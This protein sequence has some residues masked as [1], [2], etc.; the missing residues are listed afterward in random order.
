MVDALET[1]YSIFSGLTSL[2]QGLIQRDLSTPEADTEGRFYTRGWYTGPCLHQGLIQRA[3]STPGAD[4]EGRVY[5]R[6]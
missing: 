4:T 3:L 6:G 2:H 5:T 1:M